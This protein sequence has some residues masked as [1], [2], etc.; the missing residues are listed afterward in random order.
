[1]PET[2]SRAPGLE[3]LFLAGSPGFYTT[4]QTGPRENGI[5][6]GVG[7]IKEDATGIQQKK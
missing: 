4:A 5:F 3:G 7:L 1:M 2:R 6:A